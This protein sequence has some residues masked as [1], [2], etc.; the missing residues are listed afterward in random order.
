MHT[1]IVKQ[2]FLVVPDNARE[3]NPDVVSPSIGYFTKHPPPTV[4]HTQ[5]VS[6]R[7]TLDE[8]GLIVFPK[9]HC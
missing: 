1:I 7:H 8:V 6:L 5:P 9:I 2:H 3:K 4:S